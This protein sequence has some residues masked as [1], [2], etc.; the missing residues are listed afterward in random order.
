MIKNKDKIADDKAKEMEENEKKVKEEIDKKA[1][2]EK[3]KAKLQ[4][5]LDKDSNKQKSK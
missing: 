4:A 3:A 5:A 1:L 2:I